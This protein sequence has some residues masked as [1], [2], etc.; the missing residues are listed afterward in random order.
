MGVI[1][2]TKMARRLD[3]GP[4]Y[5]SN[6]IFTTVGTVHSI[7]L[8]KVLVAMCGISVNRARVVQM[9]P[10]RVIGVDIYNCDSGDSTVRTVRLVWKYSIRRRG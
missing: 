1:R 3:L 4:G 7:M 5:C 10:R 2:E 8:F 9:E 6:R